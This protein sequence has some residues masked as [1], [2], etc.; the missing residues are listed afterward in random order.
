MAAGSNIKS[1]NFQRVSEI[2]PSSAAFEY[3]DSFDNQGFSE[4]A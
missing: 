4:M 2:T 1:T 3:F